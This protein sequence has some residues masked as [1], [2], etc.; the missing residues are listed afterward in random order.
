MLTASA[1]FHI[2]A[3]LHGAAQGSL[4]ERL[5]HPFGRHSRDIVPGLLALTI[6]HLGPLPTVTFEPA[7]AG[8]TM[9]AGEL[10]PLLVHVTAAPAP[11]RMLEGLQL[12]LALGKV[13]GFDA[14]ELTT[15]HASS[16]PLYSTTC[17][18]LATAL[19]DMS[20]PAV[21][22]NGKIYNSQQKQK[23]QEH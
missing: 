6:Q 17:H 1:P 19:L 2:L 7:Q 16:C 12:A 20:I 8:I 4:A 14:G 5:A 9:L 15:L 3:G 21:Q 18:W 13:V 22:Y 23:S 11:G 10:A